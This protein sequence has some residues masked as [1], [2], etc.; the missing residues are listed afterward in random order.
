MRNILEE[1]GIGVSQDQRRR[2]ELTQVAA[3]EPTHFEHEGGSESEAEGLKYQGSEEAG[4][5]EDQ[6]FDSPVQSGDESEK[7]VQNEG[8]EAGEEIQI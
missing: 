3:E 2:E 4:G 1:L 7:E 8:Q 6:G 5:L